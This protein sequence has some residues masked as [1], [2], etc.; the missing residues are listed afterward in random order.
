MT[1]IFK[2]N[3]QGQ[4]IH[5]RFFDISDPKNQKFLNLATINHQQLRHCHSSV[6]SSSN[7]TCHFFWSHLTKNLAVSILNLIFFSCYS[8]DI[9][10]NP[11]PTSQFNICTLNICSLAN[12]LHHTALA[13]LATTHNMNLF[14][15][16]ETCVTPSTTFCELS[17]ATP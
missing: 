17:E 8:G 3:R 2:V 6:R 11:G 4:N 9:Q 14:A 12:Q 15:L 5:F 1:L 16:S 7:H 10:F 13:D